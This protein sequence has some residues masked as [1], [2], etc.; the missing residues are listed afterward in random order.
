MEEVYCFGSRDLSTEEFASMDLVGRQIVFEIWGQMQRLQIAGMIIDFKF[1]D[2]TVLVDLK[3]AKQ[4]LH[5]NSSPSPIWDN[6]PFWESCRENSF[7]FGLEDYSDITDYPYTLGALIID[8]HDG[9]IIIISDGF[10][11]DHVKILPLGKII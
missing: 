2:N 9:E 5:E 4:R 3:E 10:N 11:F 1:S 7:A 6:N 8:A